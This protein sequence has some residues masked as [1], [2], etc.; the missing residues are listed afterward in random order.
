MS[1]K[2]YAVIGITTVVVVILV[3]LLITAGGGDVF[4]YDAARTRAEYQPVREEPSNMSETG[5][6][7]FTAEKEERQEN[8]VDE[9]VEA[10]HQPDPQ[11]ERQPNVVEAE[12]QPDPQDERQPDVIEISPQLD[13]P[14]QEE[15]QPEVIEEPEEERLERVLDTQKVSF[16]VNQTSLSD[17]IGFIRDIARLNIEIDDPHARISDS[18]ISLNLRDALLRDVLDLVCEQAGVTYEIQN[19]VIIISE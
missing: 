19:N 5:G 6:R 18:L 17:A 14:Q 4:D 16:F 10:P 1:Q 7:V 15:E 8:N 13:S 9:V 3:Y 12:P 2:N 11:D